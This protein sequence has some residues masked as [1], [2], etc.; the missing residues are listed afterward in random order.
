M[1]DD[2]VVKALV[3]H[4]VGVVSEAVADLVRQGHILVD[5]H[6]TSVDNN[7]W[8]GSDHHFH[9]TLLVS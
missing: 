8:K 3:E 9:S 6:G 5:R 4:V 1:R 2:D 7:G